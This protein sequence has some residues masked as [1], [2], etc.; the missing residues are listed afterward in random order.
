MTSRERVLCA[1]SHHEP[2]R[3]PFDMLL[4]V[5]AD[6]L[7]RNHLALAPARQK[8]VGLWTEVPCGL[9]LMD[10]M[11]IDIYHISLNSLPGAIHQEGSIFF[12]EWG[13]G[14]EKITRDDGSYYF[15]TVRVP[16]AGATLEMIRRYPWPDPYDPRRVAGLR[17]ETARICRETD[18]AVMARFSNSIWEQSWYLYGLQEWLID[19][20]EKPDVTGAIMKSDRRTNRYLEAKWRRPGHAD[21][22]NDFLVTI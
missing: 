6:K 12:D 4:T 14:R 11:N 18:K 17:E 20:V 7:L 19:L 16:L 9:D 5:D 8:L 10:R 2:D 13:V 3:V 21:F 1:L 22:T 15:E